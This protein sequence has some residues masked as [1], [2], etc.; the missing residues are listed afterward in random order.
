MQHHSVYQPL[1]KSQLLINS[2]KYHVECFTHCVSPQMEKY[3]QWETISTANWAQ[4]Q[5][6]TVLF[7]LLCKILAILQKLVLGIIPQRLTILVIFTFG[8]LVVLG[9]ILNLENLSFLFPS[10]M[11]L[12]K[13]SLGLP[14][15]IPPNWKIG[16]IPGETIQLGNLEWDIINLCINLQKWRSF[17][18]LLS[19]GFHLAL[20]LLF[21]F[22]IPLK[23]ETISM[24]S[25]K[26]ILTGRQSKNNSMDQFQ[27]EYHI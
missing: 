24:A 13:G 1:Q 11:S 18:G 12:S 19:T 21:F 4:I 25:N 20:I 2:F 5:K 15:D 17:E 8:V 14:S 26:N 3:F 27:T 7:Q 22:C 9:N 23:V 6:Q 10:E 16:S